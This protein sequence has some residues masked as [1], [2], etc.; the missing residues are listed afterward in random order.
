MQKGT[1]RRL[2]LQESLIYTFTGQTARRKTNEK[3]WRSYKT[4]G[5]KRSQIYG[6]LL[7]GSAVTYC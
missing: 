2:T 1:Q 7:T 4:A 6:T 5:A 3:T